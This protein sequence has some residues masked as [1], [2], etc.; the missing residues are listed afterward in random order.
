MEK[1]QEMKN[2][3]VTKIKNLCLIF[4]SSIEPNSSFVL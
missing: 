2:D 4:I 3:N 1:D